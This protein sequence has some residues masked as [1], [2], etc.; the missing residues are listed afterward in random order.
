MEDGTG[1]VPAFHNQNLAGTWLE[2]WA[3]SQNCGGGVLRVAKIS[4]LVSAA[5]SL[6]FAQEGEKKDVED[7]FHKDVVHPVPSFRLPQTPLSDLFVS[8]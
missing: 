1:K 3:E 4:R 2:L 6:R 8:N 7:H 5:F